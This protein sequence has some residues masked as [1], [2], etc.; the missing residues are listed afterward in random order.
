MLSPFV[1]WVGR[2]RNV[3]KKHLYKYIPKNFNNYYEYIN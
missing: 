2:K 3:I 1:K